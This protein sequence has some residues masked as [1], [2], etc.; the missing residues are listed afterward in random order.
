MADIKVALEL[1]NKQYITGLRQ[2]ETAAQGFATTTSTSLA[3]VGTAFAGIAASIAPVVAAFAGLGAMLATISFADELDDLSRATDVSIGKILQLQG[4]LATSGGSAEDAATMIAKL[5]REIEGARLGSAESQN[6]LAKL[7]FTLSDMANL[8]PE[9]GIQKT[10]DALASMPNATERNA[11][12]F[13]LLGRSAASIDWEGVAAGTAGATDK[14]D[15]FTYAAEVAAQVSDALAGAYKAVKLALLEALVPIMEIGLQLSRLPGVAKLA[16]AAGWIL[17]EAFKATAVVV[18]NVAFV[19]DR[20]IAGVVALTEAGGEAARGNFANAKTIIAAYNTE[21]ATL[22]ANLDKWQTSV[23]SA[24]AQ[25]EKIDAAARKADERRRANQGD[26][27]P[28][29]A[30]ANQAQIEAIRGLADTYELLNRKARDKIKL[31]FELIGATQENIR[32]QAEQLRINQA[33]ADAIDKLETQRRQLKDSMTDM[34]AKTAIDQTIAKI[35]QQAIADTEAATQIIRNQESVIRVRERS[36]ASFNAAA[37][38]SADIGA[39]TARAAA[40]NQLTVEKRIDV[41]TRVNAVLAY[42]NRLLEGAS[43]QGLNVEQVAQLREAIISAT[44]ETTYLKTAYDRVGDAIDTNL[45]LTNRFQTDT[46]IPKKTIDSV[47]EYGSAI[48]D[49]VFATGDLLATTQKRLAAETLAQQQSIEM[50]QRYNRAQVDQLDIENQISDLTLSDTEK[51]LLSTDRL[52]A[53]ETQ[54]AILRLQEARGPGGTST[55]QERARIAQGITDVYIGQARA[56]ERLIAQSREFSTGWKKAMADYVDSVGNA[57][58]RASNLFKKATQGMEDAIVNFVKTGKFEFRDFVNSMLEELLRSQIRQIFA[59][60]MS[61]MSNSIPT[62]GGG[63]GGGGG[64]DIWGTVLDF[65]KSLLGFANGGVVPT[66]GP[67]IVGERGPELLYGAAGMTVNPNLGGG[68]VNYYINA[69]DAPSFRALI[70]RDPGFIHAVS[71]QGRRSVPG[72]RR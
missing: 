12:A 49:S 66:N 40:A 3:G 70:A 29:V 50:I 43:K 41:E 37:Q 26:V 27:R 10:I 18:G 65:G 63:S 7:G 55:E 1:D 5:Q 6:A 39:L 25:Q 68:T 15:K 42:R 2:S 32:V 72:T 21:S 13:Q 67:V 22:R 64:G 52:I 56:N 61:D 45:I 20:L 38:F 4:A 62:G 59:R 53:K 31:D 54:L 11:L 47:L 17:V 51:R 44:D 24:T 30:I 58:D 28:A 48:R 8:T 33:A 14:Y 60:T 35:K 16:S 69:V 34:A 9:Q 57:A 71:E 23:T 36:A 19:I 46:P